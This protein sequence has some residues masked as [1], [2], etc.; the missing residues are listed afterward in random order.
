MVCWFPWS[1][2]NNWLSQQ[3]KIVGFCFQKHKDLESKVLNTADVILVTSNTTKKEFEVLTTKPIEVIT[4]GF[5]VEKIEKQTL[6]NKFSL[7]HIGSFYQ[8]EIQEF[9][10]NA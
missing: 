2:D 7:A 3:I 1:L 4:N 8:K 6:D 10:G 5:D 9:C